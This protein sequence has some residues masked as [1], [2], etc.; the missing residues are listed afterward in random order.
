MDVP[1][2]PPSGEPKLLLLGVA[3]YVATVRFQAIRLL[4]RLGPCRE[5][6]RPRVQRA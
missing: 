1:S 2:P 6:V 5:G 3:A 4:I